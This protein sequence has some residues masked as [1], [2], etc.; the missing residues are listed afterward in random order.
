MIFLEV[1]FMSLDELALRAMSFFLLGGSASGVMFMY[2]KHTGW[3]SLGE[4]GLVKIGDDVAILA[5]IKFI[6][7]L[8][9][10]IVLLD[11]GQTK[12]IDLLY[13]HIQTRVHLV[14]IFMRKH[15]KIT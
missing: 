5:S 12:T 6:Q 11:L 13:K 8:S 1:D 10:N 14:S 4:V 3:S 15:A 2:A 9:C 7:D